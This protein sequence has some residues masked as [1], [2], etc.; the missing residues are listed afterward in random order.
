MHRLRDALI[1]ARDTLYAGCVRA[2][3]SIQ[4]RVGERGAPAFFHPMRET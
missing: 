1:L 2:C 3:A 4:T